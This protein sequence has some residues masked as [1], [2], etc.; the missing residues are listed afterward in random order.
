[1]ASGRLQIQAFNGN[2]YKPVEN[3][4]VTILNTSEPG[5]RQNI[6][7]QTDSSGLTKEVEVD[8]PPIQ[9]SQAP[10]KNV[11]YKLYD[12]KV[13]ASGFNDFVVKG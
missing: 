13:E 6:N 9:Y 1:M 12:V 3:A 2:T 11:P 5:K 7:M 4:K 8:A 10:S